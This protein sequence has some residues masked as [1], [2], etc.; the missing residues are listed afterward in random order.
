M[1]YIIDQEIC[2]QC[3]SCAP[4]CKNHA[5]EWVEHHYMIVSERCDL[6]GTCREYCPVDNAIVETLTWSDKAQIANRN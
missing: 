5:I 2:L 1:A 6:C 3:G 4:F